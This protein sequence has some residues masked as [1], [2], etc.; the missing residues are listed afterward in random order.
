MTLLRRL[1]LPT[2]SLPTKLMVALSVLVTVVIAGSATFL[3][4]RERGER[5]RRLEERATRIADLFEQSLAQHLWNADRRA[6]QRQ[7]DALAPN[8]EVAELTVTAVGYGTVATVGPRNVSDAT[9]VVVRVRPI[10]YRQFE[11]S[12]PQTIGEV[13]VVLTRAEAEAAFARARWAILAMAAAVVLTLYA[14]TSVLLKWLVRTPI[15]R[16]EAMVDRLATG[17]LDARCPVDSADELGRLAERVNVMADRLRGSTVHLRESE[18]RFRTFV[19]HATDAFFLHD[20]QLTVIDVNRQACESLGYSREDLIGMHPRDFDVGLD[21]ASVARLAE[22][23]GA[24]ETVT[25]ESRHRRKDGTVFPVEIRARRFPQ[26]EHRL[27]YSLVRDITERKRA[28][29][30]LRESEERFRTLVQFSFDVYWETDAQHRFTRQEFADELADAP[31][32]G[33][34]IGKT[35]WGVPYLEPDEEAWRKHR[36]TLDAHLPFRDFEL[37]RPTP[38]GSKR[39]VSVSGLPMFDSTGRFLGYRGVGRHITERKRAEAE[40]RARQD[41]L[42]L[43]QNA[44]RAVAFDWY[45]GARE[46]ENHWSPELERMYGLEPGTFDRTERGWKALVHP[47][48]WPAVKVAINRAHESGDVAAEY[49]V[50]HKDGTVHWLRA[51]GRMFFDAKGQPERIVGFMIDVTDWRRAEEALRE[52]ETRFRTFVDHAADAFFM[53][54]FDRGTVLDVNRCACESLGYT[55]EELIGMTPLV[56]DVDLNRVTLDSIAKRAAA[57]ETVVFARHR[58]RRKNGSVFPVEEQTSVFWHGGRRFLLKVA[59][60]ISER[61]QAEEQHERLRQLEAELAHINRVSMLGE[62]TASIAHEVNQPLSGVVSNGSACLR[63]LAGDMPNVEEAREAARRI[64]RDGKRAGELIARVRALTRRAATPTE[65]VDLNESIEEVLTLV[66]DEAKR[67]SAIIRT[68]FADDRAPVAGD[69]VQLQQVVLNLI[70]NAIEAMSSVGDRARELVITTRNVGADHV[71]VTVED[72]GTG[73]DPSAMER[74]FEP[75]YT[76]KAS[77]MGMGL[78]ICR[79]ILQSHGGRLWATVKDGPGTMFHFALPKYRG[80]ES[81]AEVEGV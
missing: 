59:R 11:G 34:E 58:H 77:G 5:L 53:L 37:A 56:F 76:T 74:I 55:R 75:F 30:E 17:D 68:Q 78:S 51:T 81:H 16:L 9:G 71:Q 72:S 39:W 12:P 6:I 65:K 22:R 35:R 36:A 21:E 41:L 27:R 52:S 45:I 18:A 54:D 14:A 48:D 47:D 7:L 15:N 80:E 64:V 4:E 26:G 10:T 1:R 57:G 31:A 32:P 49:R 28:E 3:V 67:T 69:R 50:I 63:W 66:A 73:L 79:S 40:L 62:L 38:D 61:V 24:G 42:D 19:D 13:K 60:N 43:A 70:M 20:D 25:F 29:A 44:A 23:V 33:S 8:R 2:A 46:T